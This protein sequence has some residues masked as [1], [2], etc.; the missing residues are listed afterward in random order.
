M[1][2]LRWMVVLVWTAGAAEDGPAVQA[3][4]DLYR[5]TC[6]ACHGMNLK[7]GEGPNLFRSRVVVAGSPQ[8]LVAVLREGIPGT[9]MRAYRWSAEQFDQ[10]VAFLH[11]KTRPGAG[12]PLTGDAAAGRVVFHK[13]GCAACHMIAGS[14]GVLGPDLS[15]VALR[16]FP[17]DIRNSVVEPDAE[18]AAGYSKVTLTMQDGRTLEGVLKNEDNF[19]LQL[20]QANGE[21]ALV[22][23][24][25]VRRRTGGATSPMPKPDLA[26]SELRDLLAFL[27]RQ[28]APFLSFPLTFQNY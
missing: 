22:D 14:G 8:A 18:I 7:G 24:A 23:R 20:L 19:S 11:S 21:Y 28:R 12:P 2:A 4:A 3:G 13:A 10:L 5:R 16:S 26:P 9:E 6:A 15:S 1:R 27:D 25:E 17:D